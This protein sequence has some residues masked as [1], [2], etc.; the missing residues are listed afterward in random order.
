V[1]IYAVILAGGEGKRA[2]GNKLSKMLGEKPILQWVIESA[3]AAKFKGIILVSGKE[4]NFCRE[5]AEKFDVTHIFNERWQLG[6]S[7]TLLKG[8]EN[9]PKDADGFAVMLGD[10]PFIKAETINKLICE[11]CKFQ[12]I[13]V[14]VYKERRGHPP[15]FSTKY[16]DEIK[17][18]IGDKGAREIIKNHQDRVKLVEVDDEGVII[19]IDMFDKS[20]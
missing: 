18:V 15:I 10:M 3:K 11:F 9:L 2:G 16:I 20:F 19:D 14:P 17:S 4:K 12:E 6:M 5:M 7:S 1:N 8:I 13:V